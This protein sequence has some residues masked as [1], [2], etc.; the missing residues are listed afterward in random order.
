[1]FIVQKVQ[2]TMKSD[3]VSSACSE[4]EQNPGVALTQVL[5]IFDAF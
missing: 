4:E 2:I 3:N 1:M 5:C